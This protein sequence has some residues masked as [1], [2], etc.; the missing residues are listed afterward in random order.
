MLDYDNIDDW[1]PR[2]SAALVDV[3]PA[4]VRA[5]VA[6]RAPE[7]IEDARDH[8]FSLV[9]HEPLVTTTLQWLSANT[10]AA[11]HGSRLT[12]DEVASVRRDGLL[13]LIATTRRTRLVRALARH[14]DWAAVEPKLDAVIRAHGQG[15]RSGHREGQVHLTLSRAGLLNGFNHYLLRG[16]EFDQHVARALL[17]QEGWELLESEGLPMVIQVELNGGKA[18]VGAHPH[19]TVDDMR[20]RDEVPNIAKAFLEAWSYRLFDTCYQTSS[21]ELDCGI[22][23]LEAVPPICIRKIAPL[24]LVAG[25]LTI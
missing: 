18:L 2:M 24:D 1:A 14:R 20:Q 6:A 22:R 11:Y 19:F 4:S 17:G 9:A 15:N 5:S 7:Y 13:P 3:V 25:P 8:L 21:R 16:S 23:F 10:I 12:E